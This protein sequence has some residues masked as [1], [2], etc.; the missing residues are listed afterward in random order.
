MTHNG[1]KLDS[2]TDVKDRQDIR[3]MQLT[4]MK[5]DKCLIH[6]NENCCSENDELT[7]NIL[8]EFPD[9][10]DEGSDDSL[11][12]ITRNTQSAHSEAK[13]SEEF[14]D[15]SIQKQ[16]K[17]VGSQNLRQPTYD[18]TSKRNGYNISESNSKSKADGFENI[19]IS[20]NIDA[21]HKRKTSDLK[22][23]AEEKLSTDDDELDGNETP[24]AAKMLKDSSNELKFSSREM[25]SSVNES[26]EEYTPMDTNSEDFFA[27]AE[28]SSS[29]DNFESN[30]DREINLENSTNMRRCNEFTSVSSKVVSKLSF[31]NTQSSSFDNSQSSTFPGFTVATPLEKNPNEDQ[32]KDQ[33]NDL[34]SGRNSEATK[35]IPVASLQDSTSTI[36]N[37]ENRNDQPAATSN[38]LKIRSEV[39]RPKKCLVCRKRLGLVPIQCRCGGLYCSIHRYDREHNCTFDYKAMGAEEIRRNNP[40]VIAEKIHKL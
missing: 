8:Y 19:I 1:A 10:S 30:S 38:S 17:T 33:D 34:T 9:D 32:I 16:G 36:T 40:L 14:S 24:R 2:T 13:Q 37:E 25:M 23:K 22:R 18:L 11:N 7:G 39:S 27:D 4:N 35:V 20:R 29:S 5:K 21:N 28:D 31:T 15:D 26:A 3:L 12:N 6:E